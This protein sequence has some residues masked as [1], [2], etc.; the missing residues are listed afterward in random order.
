[1]F[2]V[3]IQE[4]KNRPSYARS[5]ETQV[6]LTLDGQIRDPRFVEYLDR[7][8]GERQMSL[9]IDDFLVLDLVRAGESVPAELRNRL[10]GLIEQ[11]VIEKIGRGRGVR[12]VLSQDLY[13]HVGEAG[14]YTRR[15]GLDEAHN[16]ELLLQHIRHCGS[17]GAT[18]TE[19]KQVLPDKTEPQISALLRR[20]KDAGK[21]RVEGK[22]KGARWFL[23]DANEDRTIG[24]D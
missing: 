18:K 4:G 3:C 7:L 11:G 14:T 24:S 12:H 23:A 22:T 16:Q 19:F 13:Q 8:A 5:D 6:C 1:M 2:R 9:T 10:F 21:V 20:L 15:K 17:Q